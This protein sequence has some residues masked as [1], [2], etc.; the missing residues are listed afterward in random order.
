M[1][2]ATARQRAVSVELIG[3]VMLSAATLLT[4]WSA[5]Q[6]TKWS[7]EMA[8]AFSE[9]NAARTASS[10]AT[11]TANSQRTVDVTVFGEYAAAVAVGDEALAGF[12]R[13]RFRDEFVP[14]FEAWQ[15]TEPL[16]N[17][18]AP[19][20]PFAMDEYVLDAEVRAVQQLEEAE[21]RGTFARTANQ[22]GDNYV[23]VSVLFASVLFFVGI[24][25]KLTRPRIAR[26]LL[27]VAGALLVGTAVT[28]LT[29]P[30]EI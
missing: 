28:L 15:A 17:P 8:L 2:P 11:A 1:N 29:F 22:R 3:A 7:G 9:A 14:A 12:F 23:L 10:V 5:F 16:T 30:V 24:A 19:P 20:T 27:V 4:A 26:G 21:D 13:D 18:Q 25:G 6:A